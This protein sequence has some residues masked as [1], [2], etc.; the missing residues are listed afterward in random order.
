MTSEQGGNRAV[1]GRF[2]PGQSGNPGGRPAG[3]TIG[4]VLRDKL[5]EADADGHTPAE[6]IA[7]TLI[8]LAVGGD[9]RA[10]GLIYDRVEGKPR[11]S[12][13]LDMG[14]GERGYH[15]IPERDRRFDDGDGATETDFPDS[16]R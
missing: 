2:R 8:G 14:T 4:A 10:I 11:Q 6:R 1:N 16:D 5:D 12:V 7:N 15:F 3:K 13:A 9:V